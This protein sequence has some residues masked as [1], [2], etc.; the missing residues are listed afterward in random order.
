MAALLTRIQRARTR[1]FH[2]MTAPEARA[3]Y[4]AAAEVLDL[5]RAPLARVQALTLPGGDGQ[6]RPARL[7]A[8]SFERLPVLLYLHGGGFVV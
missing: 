1:P 6:P 2:A 3:A 8:P 7:V 5:P 4:Q